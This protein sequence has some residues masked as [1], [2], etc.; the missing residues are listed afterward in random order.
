MECRIVDVDVDVDA[1]KKAVF[2]ASAF[3]REEACK[4]LMV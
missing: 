1:E 4:R 2:E 3:M